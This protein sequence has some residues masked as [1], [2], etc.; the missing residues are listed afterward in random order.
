MQRGELFVLSGPSGTGKTTLIRRL[1]EGPL[2]EGGG[3]VY[4][5]SHTTRAARAGEVDG[6][7][8]HFVSRETFRRMIAER[9]FLEWAEVHNEYKGTSL[10]EV[11]PRLDAGVDVLLDI[12]VQGAEQ[13]RASHPEGHFIFTLPPGFA[14]LRRRLT[15]RDL[16]EPEEISRRLVVSLSEIKRYAEFKYVIINDDLDRACRGLAAIILD[17]RHRLERLEERI[18]QVLSEFDEGSP[19]D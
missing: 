1:L 13:V 11:M 7:D 12:D 3:L 8:Y 19:A 6:R 17:K 14:E 18:K 4:S 16:D 2:G 5:V 9:R 10:E 15:A